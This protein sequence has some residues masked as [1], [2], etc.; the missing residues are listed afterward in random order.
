MDLNKFNISKID[1][2]GN[3]DYIICSLRSGGVASLN[4]DKKIHRKSVRTCENRAS[5]ECKQDEEY[6]VYKL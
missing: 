5:G 4:A 2:V 6:G 3:G 1:V